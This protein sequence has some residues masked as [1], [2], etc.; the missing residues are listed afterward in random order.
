MKQKT[1]D[2][3]LATRNGRLGIGNSR[4]GIALI[5]TLTIMALLLI[6]AMA[7]MTNMRSERQVSFNY[8]R[9]VEAKQAAL[10]GLNTAI[11]KMSRFYTD[12]E[13][14]NGSVA[15]MAGRF[16]YTNGSGNVNV[17]IPGTSART[18]YP[19]NNTLM[20]SWIKGAG[21]FTASSTNWADKINLNGGN[22]R[23]PL[24]VTQSG[25][26]LPIANP[27]VNPARA[28][29]AGNSWG[30]DKVGI[31][32][33]YMRTYTTRGPK[34]AFWIDDESSKINIS[35]AYTKDLNGSKASF[36]NVTNFT[37]TDVGV[38]AAG[39]YP[40]A[41][42]VQRDVTKGINY[43]V[44]SVDL[45][46]LD[47]ETVSPG[48][49]YPPDRNWTQ[50][51]T[52]GSIED[53]RNGGTWQ[54]FQTPDEVLSLNNRLTMNDY[55]AVKSCLTAWSVE[56]EDPAQLFKDTANRIVTRTNIGVTINT[57]AEAKKLYD[58]LITTNNLANS[59]SLK[60]CFNNATFQLKYPGIK[61]PF[62]NGCVQQI[63]ANIVSYITDPE[64][65][66]NPPYGAG[67]TGNP[68][69]PT[70]YC[71]LWKA[72]YMNE[73]AF[74]FCWQ[75]KTDPGTPP[76]TRY[77][78]WAAMYVELI[79]PYEIDLP[80]TGKSENY[81]I[82][83]DP[84]GGAASPPLAFAVTW[85]PPP[86]SV[87]PP[88]AID[89]S[90]GS[91]QN[92]IKAH[93]YSST[94][95]P[96]NAD[97]SPVPWVQWQW[98]L[99]GTITTNAPP[100]I[101]QIV[102]TM[103][104]AIRM[105]MANGKSTGIIDWFDRDQTIPT[106]NPLTLPAAY[107]KPPVVDVSEFGKLGFPPSPPPAADASYWSRNNPARISIAKNDPRVHQWYGQRLSG[108][109]KGIIGH[110]DNAVYGVTLKVPDASLAVP[111]WGDNDGRNPL[112]NLNTDGS[113]GIVDFRGGD[114]E[115]LNGTYAKYANRPEYR[116][117][118][119]I[120]EGGM[121]SIGELGFIHTGKPWRSLSLQAYGA[122]ADET[123][124]MGSSTKAIPD[125]AILDL[126]SVNSPPIY[127][128]VNIN[129][130]GWHLGNNT[131]GPYQGAYPNCPTFEEPA[132]YP[133]H[134]NLLATWN[135][136]LTSFLTVAR[137]P[138]AY[139]SLRTSAYNR[140]A[141]NYV[142]DPTRD[143]ASVPLA[144]ALNVMPDT[145]YKHRNRLANYISY[146][147]HPISQTDFAPQGDP[148]DTTFLPNRDIWN[149]YYTVG[150][151]C[152]VPYMT[153]RFTDGGMAYT[154]ADKEDTVR[155]II[156]VLTT[157]GDVFTVHAIGNADSGEARLQAVVEH[158]RDP[159]ATQIIDRNKFRI[160]QLQWF[161]E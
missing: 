14:V 81:T 80:R 38:T 149:P 145:N 87:L 111:G 97:V 96:L 74:G 110:G 148:A 11:A 103:P 19:T 140:F 73:I 108:Q 3:K 147:Y 123:G 157:R 114:T 116:S 53:A 72:A 25:I 131:W 42:I 64:K 7:F 121:K 15:T 49:G 75:R 61:Q 17:P 44:S 37:S 129:N 100:A 8:R 60:R 93:S 128:R 146:R 78:L 4:S 107:C 119:A 12:A 133:R 120:A 76:V 104:K 102:I 152:E 62:T 46:M 160:R 156:N 5:I 77:Q 71:G 29:S 59:A 139:V 158:V 68:T 2:S 58:F 31:Y 91:V 36:N 21:V 125:W 144:A 161:S 117:N 122:Q 112:G 150:Q 83:M 101:S 54:P 66:N 48:Y 63:A 26:Y 22:Y 20:F 10:A 34:F 106:L 109:P 90:V 27:S 86:P 16:Y 154:D 99:T 45:K 32:A 51:D 136:G 127:G 151:I 28:G 52:L 18:A 39:L 23:W 153:N 84:D 142:T 79:N 135:Y 6:L 159:S 132:L 56:N 82:E 1:G 98:Q 55:Q 118:F 50:V 92:P 33:G 155:R 95:S 130:G 30:P 89:N 88:P 115:T 70:G 105:T 143:S 138:W 126:F 24:D 67:V 41:K 137:Y 43:E 134:P 113:G 69:L 13:A 40:Y 85:A 9:Q 65:P 35:N 141:V 124:Q 94:S 47:V 57:P